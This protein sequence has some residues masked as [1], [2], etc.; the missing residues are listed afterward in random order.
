M[1]RKR[2]TFTVDLFRDYQP[3]PVVDR[4]DHE[5]VKAYSLAGKL[6]KAVALTMEESGMTR[7]ELAT[8]VSDVTKSP[9]S[10]AM[11]DAYASQAREQH[12]ISAVRLAAL[13]TI[14]EDPR[15]LNVLL[16]DAG[17]IVIPKKYEALLKR[18][19]ARELR[20]QLERE[21]RAADAEW[22]AKR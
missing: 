19:R 1:S 7:D 20:E 21:E 17:F 15:A 11:L 5:E 18:E 12:S 16:E 4:F 2:D 14:T 9:V 3:A 8:A 22:R 13:I 10:K 6:S